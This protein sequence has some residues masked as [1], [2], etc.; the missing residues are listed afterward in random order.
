[1]TRMIFTYR[2]NPTWDGQAGTPKLLAGIDLTPLGVAATIDE[3]PIV[4]QAL[5]K[6][7]PVTEVYKTFVAGL[8]LERRS[9]A[10]LEATVEHYLGALIHYASLPEYIFQLGER[11]W[12]IYR[13]EGQLL[14]RFPGSRHFAAETIGEL[15]NDLADHFKESGVIGYR[16]EMTVFNLSR[17]DLQ[18]Y[19]PI[20]TLR[21]PGLAEIPVF[22]DKEAVVHL[23]APINGRP[24]ITELADG[25]GLLELPPLV[26]DYLVA[27]GRLT[28]ADD[29]SVRKLSRAGW[30]ALVSHVHPYS[31]A[32]TYTDRSNG[33]RVRREIP[34]YVDEAR[35]KLIAAR[36]NRMG[37]VSL[38]FA[39]DVPHLQFK[40]GEE[41]TEIGKI[42]VPTYVTVNGIEETAHAE[43]VTARGGSTLAALAV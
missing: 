41:L 36:A 1:M 33:G 43:Y 11:A 35:G 10:K 15:R 16:K 2:D 20:C 13:H 12:P 39:A 29:V 30:R 23:V 19:A 22:R 4:V 14:A 5:D 32:F 9:L 26:G 18:L 40:V 42:S 31:C 38:H 7:E 3:L 28:D 17:S 21:A 8:P 24:I 27:Q 34:I 37:R 6:T 25:A